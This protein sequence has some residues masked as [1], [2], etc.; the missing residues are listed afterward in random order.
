MK[1]III[2]YFILLIAFSAL[3]FQSCK[4][5]KAEADPYADVAGH[6]F[7]IRQ[8]TQDEWRTFGGQAFTILKTVR[9]NKKTDSS[10]TTSDTLNWGNIFKT[11]F[12]TEISDRKYLGQYT[13][14][15]FDDNQ[16]GTRNFYYKAN[17]EDMFTQKLLITANQEN[18]K[19]MGIYIETFKKTIWGETKQNLYY[20]PMRTIQIQVDEKP[21]VGSRK[22]RVTQYYFMR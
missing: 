13:Y 11:F 4:K 22:Y 9:E 15:Q 2:N 12:E 21:T 17:D 16:E 19:V 14:T 18:N 20:A 3:L 6:Y 7:S 10:Y 1:K 8:F 5:K